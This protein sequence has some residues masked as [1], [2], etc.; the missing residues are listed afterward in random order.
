MVSLYLDAGCGVCSTK[1]D[2]VLCLEN[3][4][5][6]QREKGGFL[7][8]AD[9]LSCSRW[10]CEGCPGPQLGEH[11]NSNL[12]P[13]AGKASAAPQPVPLLCQLHPKL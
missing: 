2:A 3:V 9:D 1:Q 7:E 5:Q 10:L 8:P 12:A 13:G 6:F 4:F 11:L